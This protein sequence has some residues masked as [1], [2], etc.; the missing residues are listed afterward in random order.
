MVADAIALVAPPPF[1]RLSLADV[2]HKRSQ[3]RSRHATADV[4]NSDLQAILGDNVGRLSF[5]RAS[6]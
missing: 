6:G 1:C 2:L 3:S 5:P 4:L